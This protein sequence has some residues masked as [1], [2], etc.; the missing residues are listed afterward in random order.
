MDAVYHWVGFSIVWAA[1]LALSVASFYLV[2][3]W[4]IKPHW[5]NA[6]LWLRV[7]LLG[8]KFVRSRHKARVLT[9]AY[10]KTTQLAGWERNLLAFTI[11]QARRE[12][13]CV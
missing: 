5:G 13:R 4:L 1:M 6:M 8:E 9:A 7:H 12:G 2:Y 3:Q 10:Q 11:R